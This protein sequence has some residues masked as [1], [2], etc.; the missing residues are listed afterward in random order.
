MPCP[1]TFLLGRGQSLDKRGWEI[2]AA[3]LCHLAGIIY[4]TPVLEVGEGR[5]TQIRAS[6]WGGEAPAAAGP[7]GREGCGEDMGCCCN[8]TIKTQRRLSLYKI[9][10]SV[11]LCILLPW[12]TCRP[13]NWKGMG[14]WGWPWMSLPVKGGLQTWGT[15][16]GSTVWSGRA[17]G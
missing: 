1:L 7:D 4:W 17:R 6:G 12:E 14:L 5:M 3:S 8:E 10:F 13:L 11:G 9:A 15:S 16:K 2:V